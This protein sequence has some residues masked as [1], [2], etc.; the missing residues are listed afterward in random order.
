M[1]IALVATV[2]LCGVQI[3]GAGAVEPATQSLLSSRGCCAA[4][5]GTGNK[6]ITH[7]GKT[8]VT[9]LDSTE[10]GFFAVVRTLDRATG[11]WSPTYTLGK[12]PDDHGRPAMT[13]DGQGYLHLVYG[14]HQNRIPYRR[15]LRP[16]DAS[17][18]SQIE[19]FGGRLSYPT[20]V[21]GPDNALYLTGRFG[22]DGVRLYVRPPGGEWRDR[23]LIIKR[24][25]DCSSYAAFHEGLAWGPDHQTLHLSC[26][27]FQGKSNNSLYWGTVQSIN[28]MRTRDF[29]RSWER[30]DGT[31]IA[32]P[33][34][35]T[36]MDVLAA[37]EGFDPKP[38]LRNTGAIVVDSRGRPYVLYYRNS[39]TQP[40]QV[41]LVRSDRRG[42]WRSLPLQA[43]MDRVAP[44]WA[45]VD[46]RAGFTI[47]ADD[48]LCM[49]LT[50]APIKHPEARWDGKPL[51]RYFHEPAYWQNFFPKARR[52][53][54]VESVDAGASFAKIDVLPN[55]PHTAHLQASIEMPT[56]FNQIP[57]AERPSLLYH[58]GVSHNPDG[59]LI[60]NDVFFVRVRG[61]H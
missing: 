15:S 54:W 33:A 24:L 49:A 60:D 27:F 36:S 26:Q 10:H 4:T 13:I 43:A 53:V 6:I 28:Y 11:T 21:C 47:T 17:A 42:R 37:G 51:D 9:W 58:T 34:T 52:V 16:N 31:P 35:A 2:V 57:A 59:R 55:D 39:P 45:L 48:R 56:G 50:L 20:L 14:A 23:G 19:Y 38:G 7:R 3:P 12:A 32:L 18:W 30:A 40:G 41:F 1:R 29:G 46:C 61:P 8:H 5:A 22:W 25:A 44:D